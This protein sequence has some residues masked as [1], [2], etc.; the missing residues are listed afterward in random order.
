[1]KRN[2]FIAFLC[3]TLAIA[4]VLCTTELSLINDTVP[5]SESKT[6]SADST[7]DTAETQ[8]V[9]KTYKASPLTLKSGEIKIF[10]LSTAENRNLKRFSSSAPDVATVDSGGRIDAVSPGTAVITAKFFDNSKAEC[11]V[12]VTEAEK[13][14]NGRYSTAIIA[15]LDTLSKNKK[16][17][18]QTALYEIRV[19]RTQ[20]CVTVYTYD[21]NK[22]YTVPVRAMVCSTGK[23][24]STITGTFN[25]Y[26]KHEWH[27]LFDDV[28]GYYVSGISS[29]YLFH[30]VPYYSESPDDLEV[31]EFNKLGEQA[32]LGCV[33]MSA[34]DTKWIYKNCPVGTKT[35]I[36]DDDNPGPLGKP[37]T[38]K[39]T[40]KHCG[41]DPTDS[42]KNNP[43]YS[44]NPVISGAKDLTVKLGSAYDYLSGISA[45]DTC[46]NDITDKIKVD[47]NVVTTRKGR[48]IVTYSVTDVLN[49][50]ASIDITVTVE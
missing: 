27:P 24:N 23:D 32:S 22:E 8:P 7:S 36:Y 43:Y 34:S 35:I 4:I 49:R 40:D 2:Y 39:I 47:G 42:S 37:E 26:F 28:Y 12:T 41:W 9:I 14:R 10:E 17:S 11:E 21:K 16:S 25:I 44:K 1:M 50:S 19:N 30:S 45:V 46:S 13:K 5:A 31:E 15:N 6:E 20:N 48:Y 29:D 3:F 18:S 38:I 33:R